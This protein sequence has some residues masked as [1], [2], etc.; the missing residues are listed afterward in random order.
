MKEIGNI[1]DIALEQ[2][3]DQDAKI[4]FVTGRASE[5][6]LQYGGLG[7]RTRY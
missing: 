4:E 2:A 5:I 3:R 6:L 1:R 7:A